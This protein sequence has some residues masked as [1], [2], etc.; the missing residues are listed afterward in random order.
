M[1][2]SA[3]YL[4]I[5]RPIVISIKLQK[6]SQLGSLNT[7]RGHRLWFPKYI[8]FHSLKID[9]VLAN[10]AEPDEMPHNVVSICVFTVC[11]SNPFGVSGLQSVKRYKPESSYIMEHM[12]MSQCM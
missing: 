4:T 2:D 10:T 6:I 12:N 8:V 7:L 9:F 1:F 11:K 3:A 5:F